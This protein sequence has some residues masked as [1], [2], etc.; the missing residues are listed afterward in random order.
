MKKSLLEI[1]QLHAGYRDIKVLDDVSIMLE[2]GTI[3]VLMG[4]N[5]AGKSTLLKSVFSITDITDGKILFKHKEITG[6][7]A[8]KLMELGIAFVSQGKI[9]F[10]TMS[11]E[12]NLRMGAHYLKDSQE[13]QNRLLEIYKQFPVLKSKSRQ[14][15]FAL[16]GGEQ[17]MLAI[18]R[19]LMSKPKLLLMDEPSLGL[20]PKLVKEVFEKI[21]EIKLN[22]NTTILI[23][24][25]N[26]KS[27]MEVAD[28]GYVLLN[29]RVVAGDSCE[30][31]KHSDIMQ[32][33]FVGAFD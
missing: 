31:L 32:K 6:L 19:A 11:V 23:V 10:D 27:L 22:F 16:S 29:G 33:V 20:A 25:H 28:F 3:T 2:E 4:P 24:E 1:K 30:R 13:V 18:G 14:Y 8:H 26:I 12:D 5:G 7:P 9:N 21:A 17:Q 15:A